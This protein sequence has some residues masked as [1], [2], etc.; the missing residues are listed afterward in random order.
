MPMVLGYSN[1]Q[2]GQ[3]KSFRLSHLSTRLTHMAASL[4]W[5]D[6]SSAAR[7][8]AM[9]V[10]KLF[11]EKGTVDEIGIGSV[12]DALSDALFPGTSVLHTRARYFLIV[13]WSYQYLENRKIS[14]SVIAKED[15][16]LELSL[17]DTLLAADDHAGT[18][19]R[20]AKQR[21]KL[22]P[23]AMYWSGLGAWG[24][25]LREGSQD[26]YHR[27]LDRWYKLRE[28]NHRDDDGGTLGGSKMRNWHS[29]IPTAPPGFPRCSL[30]FELTR[31]EAEYLRERLL[32]RCRGTLLAHLVDACQ[33]A[34]DVPFVWAHPESADF[35]PGV[36]EVVAH[37]RNFS[38]TIH[39]AAL[40]YNVMLT[41][42]AERS[43]LTGLADR[44]EEHEKSF[45]AWAAI[46][47]N[48]AE[49]LGQWS[50][51]AFWSMVTS[52]NPRL[53]IPTRGF[54]DSWFDLALAGKSAA[55]LHHDKA[56]RLIADRERAIK[57]RLARLHN[58][59]ALQRW[60][61]SSGAEQLTYRW[62]PEVRR[63]VADIQ[64]GLQAD[65]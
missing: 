40:L 61:G 11:E 62:N 45:T 49:S 3:S 57:G 58:A 6:A 17:I 36:Q 26:Q 27:S 1:S 50:R 32:T 5:L 13:P 16:R 54:V 38:E 24:I 20:V 4:S 31:S 60:G 29:G 33:P 51:P 53:P 7:R 21:L 41:E 48:R 15:R 55:L 37:A 63:L 14:S 44:R 35:P 56:R 18:I 9:E 46:M 30:S 43:G 47:S 65:A 39:G 23:S 8:Q 10:I 59:E 12:R 64:R 52:F 28:L 19:G 22:L 2:L 25:R 34:D 42:R